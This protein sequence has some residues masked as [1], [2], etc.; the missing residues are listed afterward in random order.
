MSTSSHLSLDNR[1]VVIIDM[2]SI[3]RKTVS[4]S[5]ARTRMSLRPSMYSS[6]ASSWSAVLPSSLVPLSFLS[7]FSTSESFD[8]DSGF[9]D[10]LRTRGVVDGCVM[11]DA[12]DVKRVS[13]SSLELCEVGRFMSRSGEDLVKCLG[14]KEVVWM[15]LGTS[16]VVG[17]IYFQNIKTR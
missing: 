3:M 12:G 6:S 8:G 5:A 15:N 14:I 2:S 4:V 17:K 1:T 7:V 13:V 9:S 16:Y 10:M 11:A